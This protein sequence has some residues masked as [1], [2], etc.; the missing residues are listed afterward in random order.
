[1]KPQRS[2]ACGKRVS[3]LLLAW[4]AICGVL[5][6][7]SAHATD[8][9]IGV[10]G[11]RGRQ[12]A[13]QRWQAT[14]DYLSQ[15]VHGYHFRIQPLTLEGMRQAT[16]AGQLDF[17]LTNPGD[18][19][20]LEARY[21]I[22][23]LVTLRNLRG[24]NAY[25]KFGAVI[26]TRAD[27]NDIKSLQDLKGKSFMAVSKNA[28][29]GF[30]LA[31]LTLLQHGVDPFTDFSRLVFNGFP[32][33]DIVY[34]VR[35]GKV[36]AGTV[37]TDI[38][39]RMAAETKIDIR[40]FRVLASRVTP[41]FPFR[42]S[43]ALYPEWPFAKTNR[44]SDR[45][46]Q[47][48]AVALLTMP[49][50]HRAA[51]AGHYAGW[52]V[53]LD[54]HRVHD[55]FRQL[56]IGPY[57]R[58]LT[59]RVMLQAYWRWIVG[60]IAAILLMA[61]VTAYVLGLNRRLKHST[62]S[63]ERA[64]RQRRRA[65]TETQKLSSALQQSADLV[66]I[67][68][69][70]GVIEYVNP[71]FEHVTGFS[72]EETVGRKPNLVKSGMHNR[73]FY[74]TLWKTVLSGEPY[75]AVFTN[76]RKD[77]SVYYE[78]KTVTPLRDESGTVQYF[79]STGKDITDRILSEERARQ[80]E[81]QLAHVARVSTMG[82][83]ASALAHELNQPLAAIVNY[84][85][86]CV[87]RL[88]SGTGDPVSLTEALEN[89]AAQGQRSGEIIRRLRT[90]LRKSELRRNPAQINEIATEAASLAELEARHR[91][92]ELRLELCDG[93]P[94]LLADGIQVEQVILNLVR[95]AMEAIDTARSR[96]REVVLRTGLSPS[97]DLEV[98]VEDSGPGLR[99]GDTDRLFEAFF[100]TKEEGMGMGLSISRSIIEAHGGRLYAHPRNGG[101]AVF[102]F[103]L[104]AL[105]ENNAIT[106]RTHDIRR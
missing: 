53:P 48:V 59:L 95:N 60:A 102:G 98:A 55:L 9:V 11:Y 50:D 85:R 106:K 39:E 31:W 33:D 44:T 88:Q 4:A 105:D 84:A 18:Y 32:Q 51:K 36:D 73:Q 75:H 13:I 69:R 37:R 96:K 65:E 66:I 82:E 72:R 38:I 17:V 101:G 81:A 35:D 26:F 100:T 63:L 23:R 77:G 22:S 49:E 46:A 21:G 6:P 62:L 86:G 41:G 42:H 2:L 43:T 8:A 83:M 103:T 30:Q 76:R 97:G 99:A 15:R 71:T 64:L 3:L 28:F 34:A 12:N 70:D 92:V 74:A 68:D 29:G 94:P 7:A 79:V 91:R 104:P 45:L 20:D 10:L 78:E 27:R 25:T 1:M 5:A 24:G 61:T 57:Y 52:T 80:H 54:Y 58:P 89:I 19:V 56:G 40:T 67:T 87:R 14:A 16:A 93:L 90:F 47:R